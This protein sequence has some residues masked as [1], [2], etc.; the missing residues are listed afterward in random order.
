MKKFIQIIIILML[1]ILVMYTIFITNSL[2]YGSG[3][4][5]YPEIQTNIIDS[6][7]LEI[8]VTS[9]KPLSSITYSWNDGEENKIEITNTNKK[10]LTFS[11]DALSGKN[12]L[13]I[14][15]KDNE[16]N[17]TTLSKNY[18]LSTNKP[19]SVKLIIIFVVILIAYYII[20]I[21]VKSR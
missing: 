5:S 17:T 1:T 2:S 21:F 4:D 18:S 20:S 15:A 6:D 12:K 8:K 13:T 3:D 14:V 9:Q 11:I 16:D 7:K 19:I 10:E